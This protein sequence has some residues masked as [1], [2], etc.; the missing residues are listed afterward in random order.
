MQRVSLQICQR[1]F[2]FCGGEKSGQPGCPCPAGTRNRNRHGGFPNNSLLRRDS[3]R[4]GNNHSFVSGCLGFQVELCTS[5]ARPWVEVL[6]RGKSSGYL[7]LGLSE[8]L[9]IAQLAEWVDEV[10][11]MNELND[12]MN[13]WT[14]ESLNKRMQ[15]RMGKCKIAVNDMIEQVKEWRSDW[16]SGWVKEWM[17]YWL[18]MTQWLNESGE[19]ANWVNEWLNINQR[20]KE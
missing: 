7:H 15:E 8:S 17:N 18:N 2:W 3:S 16:V 1:S 5:N 19:C 10:G 12:W 9:W 14:N 4:Q 11:C 20:R 13:E 6:E